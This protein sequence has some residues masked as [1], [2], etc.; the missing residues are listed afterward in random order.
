MSMR[1]TLRWSSGPLEVFGALFVG[2]FNPSAQVQI[3]HDIA[4]IKA[5]QECTPSGSGGGGG[6]TMCTKCQDCGGQACKSGSCGSCTQNS[7]CCSPL[8]CDL[9]NNTCAVLAG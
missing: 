4:I 5:S 2:S 8:V 9:R 1:Q 7:D 6:S 3:H